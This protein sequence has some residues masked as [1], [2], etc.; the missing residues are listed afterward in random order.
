MWLLFILSLIID[1][2]FGINKYELQNDL[3]LIQTDLDRATKISEINTQVGRVANALEKAKVIN[4][5]QRDKMLKDIQAI[6][7]LQEK[8]AKLK[9]W[10]K[11]GA[12]AVAGSGVA[13][14]YRIYAK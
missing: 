3:A 4:V 6:T 2:A 13:E 7:D 5:A 11:Y 10:M 8:S 1:I 14:A 12:A 9:Q